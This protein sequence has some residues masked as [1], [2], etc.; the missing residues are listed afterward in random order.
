MGRDLYMY[1]PQATVDQWTIAMLMDMLIVCIPSL[2]QAL[3][4]TAKQHGTPKFALPYL[5]QHIL[6]YLNEIW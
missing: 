1:M 2:L 5:L 6:A 3:V 4:P